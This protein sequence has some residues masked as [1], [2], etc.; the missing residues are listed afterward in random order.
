MTGALAELATAASGQADPEDL[1]K[2]L[3]DITTEHLDVDGAGV[4]INDGELL[5]FVHADRADVGSAEKLQQLMQEGPCH[6]ALLFHVDVVVDDL[7]DPVQ[8]AWPEFVQRVLEEGF[9]SVIAVPLISRGR[10]W[11]VLDL[12]RREA[13]TWGQQELQWAHLL[14]H[15]A[16]SYLVMAADRAQALQAQ[17]ELAHAGTHDGLTGLPNRTLLF[18]RLEHALHAARRHQRTVAV[19]F[20]DLD[21]FK[22]VNDTLGHAAGDTVLATVA[23]RMN[24]SLRQE[25]TLARLAGD[26]FVLLCEDLPRASS[27]GPGDG[28]EVD[29]HVHAVTSRLRRALARPVHVAGVDLM[30]G[31]TIGVALS[32]EH[33]SADDLL[34][35]ADEAMYRAKR[36]SRVKQGIRDEQHGRGG[37]IGLT[38]VSR[39]SAG[40]GAG[41]SAGVAARSAQ[42]PGRHLER[43]LAQA[44]THD[45]LQVHYQPITEPGGGVHAVE[46]LLRWQHPQRGLLPAARFVDLA[47]DTGLIVEIGRWVIDETCAQMSRWRRE[48]RRGA[49]YSAYVNLSARELVDPALTTTLATALRTHDLHAQQLGLEVVEDS[50]SNPEVLPVLQEQEHRGHPL[51]ID[52]FGTGYSSLSRLVELPVQMA[53]IDRSFIAGL[54]HDPRR[55]ALVDAVVTVATSLD[56][57]VIAEGVETAAQASQV[58]DAGCHYLQG[59]HCGHPQPAEA[60]T[61]QWAA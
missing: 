17:Q 60:L 43:Q 29:R 27:G 36:D 48:L 28:G 3:V 5:R 12:Y 30:V 25:D 19:F 11:G 24:A 32:E 31:A 34:A 37:V 6:D 18:D 4:M 15:V 52:D 33:P 44:L 53:K 38:E 57:Q 42:R 55:R 8:T 20:I 13:G 45:Q 10:V 54:G 1:L 16:V 7:H 41:G 26:E 14:A 56:L 40:G 35:A 2:H 39:G 61:A 49:P 50:F 51:S 47:V 9:R 59:F 22:A 21:R 23:T 46:A 58:T